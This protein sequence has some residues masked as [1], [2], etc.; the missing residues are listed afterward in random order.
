M[1]LGCGMAWCVF[2]CFYTGICVIEFVLVASNGCVRYKSFGLC[3]F[4]GLVML[5]FFVFC[6]CGVCAGNSLFLIVD[7]GLFGIV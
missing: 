4:G 6:C 2:A 3:S 1:V 5:I 7:L